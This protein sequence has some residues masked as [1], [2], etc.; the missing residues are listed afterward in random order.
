MS[1]LAK[2]IVSNLTEE[3]Q[4]EL[5][6]WADEAYVIR[7]SNDISRTEKIKRITKITIRSKVTS[8]VIVRFFR[9]LKKH[10][11]DDRAWPARFALAGLTI[12]ATVGGTKMAGV[13]TAGIGVGIPIYILTSAGG[14]LLGSIIEELKDK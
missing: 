12:G 6:S 5:K 11:W 8:N 13:A 2:K 14:A 7:N 4:K 3:E 10:S 1:N 9:L